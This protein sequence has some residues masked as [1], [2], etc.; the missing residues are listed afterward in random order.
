VTTR[1]LCPSDLRALAPGD[2]VVGGRLRR[3]GTA[4]QLVDAFDAVRVELGDVDVRDGDLAI[5]RGRL[6]PGPSIVGA[7]IETHRSSGR[8]KRDASRFADLGVGARLAARAHALRA[9]RD[10]FAAWGFVEVE[11]PAVVPCPGLDTHLD[12]FEIARPALSES[13]PRYLITSP[14]Y[15]M[16]RLLVGGVPRCFQ[17]AKSFRRG[18]VGDNHN[19][20]FTMLEWY[21]AFA[22]MEDVVA[23]TEAIVLAVNAAI[24]HAGGTLARLDLATPFERLSVAD[25]F[26]RHAGVPPE[27][28]LELANGDTETFFRVLIEEVEPAVAAARRPVFLTRYPAS[29]ASLAR[30]CPDDPRFAERFELYAAGV[31]LC[32]GFG[33]L[34]DPVEQR[35]RFESDQRERRRLGLPVYPID[36]RFIAA[37]EEGM[38]PAAGNA[39]GLDR[40]VMLALGATSLRDVLAFPE[41]EL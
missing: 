24:G 5:V 2:I 13:P 35:Q 28:M 12:A 9:L 30:R 1:V 22:S 37:L 10:R 4:W 20:E 41:A 11:T 7:T 14:E 36:E 32:N 25:A 31:E 21:R 19:P 34:T 18:E 16:K 26:E 8:P 23:D 17:I 6:G 33:E 38:P 15:Q 29:M 27:R 3:A 39:L 40:L